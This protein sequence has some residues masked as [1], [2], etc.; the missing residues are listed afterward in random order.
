MTPPPVPAHLRGR[1]GAAGGGA[2]SLLLPQRQRTG[3]E[4]EGLAALLESCKLE[5]L[6]DAAVAW[7]NEQGH[8]SVGELKEVGDEEAFVNELQ[9]KP[10]KAKLLLKRLGEHA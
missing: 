9:L 7:C 6:L 5:Y 10:G 2:S 1:T 3:G 4:V 8:D